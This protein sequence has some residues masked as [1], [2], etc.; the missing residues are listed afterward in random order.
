MRW[1]LFVRGCARKSLRWVMG[2][3]ANLGLGRHLGY[4]S[5]HYQVFA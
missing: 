5:C 2:D 4:V 3:R 1:R